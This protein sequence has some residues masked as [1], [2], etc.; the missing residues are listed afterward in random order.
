MG[1]IQA[2]ARVKGFSS[3]A[4]SV[5]DGGESIVSIKTHTTM[6]SC[7]FFGDATSDAMYLGMNASTGVEDHIHTVRVRV[8][9][10]GVSD[11]RKHPHVIAQRRRRLRKRV[12]RD[13]KGHR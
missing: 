4:V 1:L 9:G 13:R 8:A 6:S 11:E 5:W 12:K 3:D 2:S 7:A 10:D